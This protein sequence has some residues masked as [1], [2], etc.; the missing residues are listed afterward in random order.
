MI[1]LPL[2]TRPGKNRSGKKQKEDFDL[3]GKDCFFSLVF[4]LFLW[5]SFLTEIIIELSSQNSSFDVRCGVHVMNRCM[6]WVCESWQDVLLCSWSDRETIYA[7]VLR[8]S[9]LWKK[10]ET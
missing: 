5:G 7:E 6:E 4:F 1:L 3:K 10:C 2:E 9:S 8:T